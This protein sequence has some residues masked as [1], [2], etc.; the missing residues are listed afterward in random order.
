MF[1]RKLPYT[2]LKLIHPLSFKAFGSRQE[3][4]DITDFTRIVIFLNFILCFKN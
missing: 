1:L 3:F 2:F 4:K